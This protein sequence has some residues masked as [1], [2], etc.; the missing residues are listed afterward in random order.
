MTTVDTTVAALRARYALAR[1]DDGCDGVRTDAGP[2][3]NGARAG[4]G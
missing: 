2:E 4:S 3:R 1:T